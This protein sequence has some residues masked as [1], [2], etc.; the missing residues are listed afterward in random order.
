MGG[1][2]LYCSSWGWREVAGFA[3]TVM[4]LPV[5]R[6]VRNFLTEKLLCYEERICSMELVSYADKTTCDLKFAFSFLS[7]RYRR[8]PQNQTSNIEKRMI[9]LRKN[10]Q[11][12]AC[13][14]YRPPLKSLEAAKCEKNLSLYILIWNERDY[15][16]PAASNIVSAQARR[17]DDGL[18]VLCRNVLS[19]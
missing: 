1:H 9:K 8:R 14:M 17:P 7:Q 3:K 2:G 16:K 11:V 13:Y 6:Y 15:V 18:M 12:Y 19:K 4:N 5:A 10:K